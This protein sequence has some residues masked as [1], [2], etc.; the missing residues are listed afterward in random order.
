MKMFKKTVSIALSLVLGCG[1]FTLAGC[2]GNDNKITMFMSTADNGLNDSYYIKWLEEKSGL[3]IEIQFLAGELNT[4]VG[5]MIAGGT[6][7]DIVFASDATKTFINAGA[8]RPMDEFLTDGGENLKSLY[9]NDLSRARV[10]QGGSL[11]Y[12]PW[13][14]GSAETTAPWSA[15]YIAQ[16]C[17]EYYADNH[18]G[19]WPIVRTLDQYFDLITDY[20]EAHPTIALKNSQ[21]R[22]KNTDTIGCLIMTDVNKDYCLQGAPL[23]LAGFPNDGNLMVDQETLTC[24]PITDSEYAYKFFKRVNEAYNDGII[25]KDVFSISASDFSTKVATGAVLGTLYVHSD[26]ISSANETVREDNPDSM[27]VP[28]PVTLEEGMVDQY[29]LSSE[30]VVRDGLMITNN[31]KKPQKAFDLIELMCTE[32]AQKL[33]HWGVEGVTYSVD[34]N[35]KFYRTD[36][37]IALMR[38]T[39]TVKE[40]GL[41]GSPFPNGK[42]NAKY[43]DGNVWSAGADPQIINRTLTEA[44]REFLAHYDV[45]TYLEFFAEPIQT[46]YGQAWEVEDAKYEYAIVSNENARTAMRAHH[47]YLVKAA[48]ATE[49]EQKWQ[50]FIS[51]QR[52]KD[53][54]IYAANMTLLIRKRANNWYGTNF[55][56]SGLNNG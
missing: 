24:T 34:E 12:I 35:G 40:Y 51:D 38:K 15:V 32:E 10:A 22:V 3:D 2:G 14:R 13:N 41:F 18:D 25:P 36:E 29:R 9:G 7:P 33:R 20:Y 27:L 28:M 31:C 16:R 39:K 55:D 45:G 48:N 50:D 56:I 52:V 6:Y 43:S 11:Y 49:F 42:A 44:D 19:E 5:S 1:A 54:S 17:L 30:I 4:V 46:L 37:Q 8:I 26:M 53:H 21:G 47:P 23:R